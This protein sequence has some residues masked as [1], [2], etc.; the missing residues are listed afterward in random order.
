VKKARFILV[1]FHLPEAARHT[2]LHVRNACVSVSIRV[3]RV[4]PAEA[5]GGERELCVRARTRGHV[6]GLVHEG[7]C[8]HVR[9]IPCL[10]RERNFGDSLFCVSRYCTG[11]PPSESSNSTVLYAAIPTCKNTVWITYHTHVKVQH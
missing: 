3:L 5:C 11:A 9:V 10:K 6:G 1:S 7:L 4:V 2:A 8:V